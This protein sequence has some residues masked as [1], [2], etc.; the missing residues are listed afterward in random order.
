MMRLAPGWGILLLLLCASIDSARADGTVDKIRKAHAVVCGIDQNEAEF[1]TTDDHGARVNFDRDLCKAVAA[2]VLGRDAK[3]IVKG[4]PDDQ[5]SVAALRSGEV[6]LIASLSADFSHTTDS[7]IGLSRPVL[8]DGV[9]LMVPVASGVSHAAGLSGKKICLLAETE[10]EVA[11]RDWFESRHLKFVPFPF[12]EEGEMEAAYITG[13]CTGLAADVTRLAATRAG[14]G[15]RANDYILL[16]EAISKDPMA[17]AFRAS[18]GQ[19]GRI[20]EWT[21]NILIQ[22]EESGV[23]S[24]NIASLGGSRDAV[25]ERL[26]GSTHEFGKGLGLDD[27]WAG[28]AIEAVG[29]YGEIFVRD[30]GS[31]SPLKLDR[32]WN[33][34]W[35]NG[36]LLYAL[37]LK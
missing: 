25:T 8:Y 7:S 31:D 29:N 14:F 5:S 17:V 21:V 34:L 33:Q 1:S 13:N 20:I 6:D 23:S 26:L 10:A 2:A 16:P 15:A 9:G 36:G 24:A 3:V 19:W 11:T 37:P 35:T 30:L 22:A 28:H 12:Q 32:G 27:Q 4:F 18:D